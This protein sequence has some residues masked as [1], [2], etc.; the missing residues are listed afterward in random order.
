MSTEKIFKGRNS[1]SNSNSNITM[2]ALAVVGG[3]EQ[4]LQDDVIGYED[5]DK[6]QKRCKRVDFAWYNQWFYYDSGITGQQEKQARHERP[7]R[8]RENDES[9]LHFEDKVKQQMHTLQLLQS[10]LEFTQLM[11]DALPRN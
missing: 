2:A 1:N 5:R 9:P 8:M 4:R 11:I 7:A 6:R 10:Q 3:G